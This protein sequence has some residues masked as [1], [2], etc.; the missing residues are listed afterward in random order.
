MRWNKRLNESE[1]DLSDESRRPN[2]V[3][4]K[5]TVETECK[6]ISI[7]KKTGWGER[8]IE[9]FVDVGHTTINKILNKRGLCKETKRKKK[10]NKYVRWERKHPNSLWQIDHSDQKIDGKWC[11]S[12]IDDCSRFSLALIPLEDLQHV[13]VLLP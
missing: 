6:I 13:A 10:R 2:T 8:K 4:K 7:K 11:L 9:N 3:Q 5:V 1:W 12:V